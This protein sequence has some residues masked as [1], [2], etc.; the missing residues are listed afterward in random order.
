[1]WGGTVQPHS[2]DNFIRQYAVKPRDLGMSYHASCAT[3]MTRRNLQNANPY[4]I[5]RPNFAYTSVFHSF[6]C[7]IVD[8]LVYLTSL[9][10]QLLWQRLYQL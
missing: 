8:A 5:K 3:L 7:R 10:R 9:R 2:K 6:S 4:K 1:M